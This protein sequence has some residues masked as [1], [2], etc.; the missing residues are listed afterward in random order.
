MA[1]IL[2]FGVKEAARLACTY[3]RQDTSDHPVAFTVTSDYMPSERVFDGLPVVPFE[4]IANSHPPPHHRFLVPMSYRDRN[5]HRA[6]I[7]E[8]VKTLGYAMISYVSPRA[9]VFPGLSIGENSMV[10]EGCVVSPGCRI[11]DNVMIQAGC[12]I[13]HDARIGDHAFLGPGAML[14][15]L[16]E[17]GPY[18]F[19][20]S[21]A[22][23]RDQVRLGEGSFIAMGSVVRDDTEPW[24]N[25]DGMPARRWQ[26]GATSSET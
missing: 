13:A 3:V 12:L 5:R 1:N 18:A 2:I 26:K 7:Y 6:R 15:G 20:G 23:V 16:V 24:V 25:Y 22:V 8:Q 19:I 10:L 4:S 17:V 21:G 11:G 14:S 9:I